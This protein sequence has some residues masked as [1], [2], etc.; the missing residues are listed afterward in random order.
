MRIEFN[1]EVKQSL[2][3]GESTKFQRC[4]S[5][6]NGIGAH[7]R[8]NQTDDSVP[9]ARVRS[10]WKPMLLITGMEAFCCDCLW[11]SVVFA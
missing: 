4:W 10:V 9:D 11:C 2:L 7:A 6:S 8:T 1:I 5:D 3:E